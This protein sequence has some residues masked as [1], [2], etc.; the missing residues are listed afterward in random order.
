MKKLLLTIITTIAISTTAQAAQYYEIVSTAR[1]WQNPDLSTMKVRVLYEKDVY[2]V[3]TFDFEDL[4]QGDI[5][6]K[7]SDTHFVYIGF[8]K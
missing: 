2:E 5:V 7:L 3:Y 1:N 8:V 4:T 6:E